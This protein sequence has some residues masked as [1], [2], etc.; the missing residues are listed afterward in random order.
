MR[1]LLVE[2]DP[3]IRRITTRILTAAGYRVIPAGSPEE[4]LDIADTNAT[5]IDLLFT[6]VV[7]P[8]MSGRGLAEKLSARVPA[9]KVL[10]MSGYTDDIVVRAGV[11][12]HDTLFL[13]KPFSQ[14]ALLSKV[15]EALDRSSARS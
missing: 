13:Q 8:E 11:L 6:D 1:L 7:L 3:A 4:A 15:R 10:Y 12:E 5:D 14:S 9:M 2:D